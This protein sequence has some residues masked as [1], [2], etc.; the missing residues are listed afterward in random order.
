[1]PEKTPG[2]NSTPL[3]RRRFLRE[4][5][6]GSVPLLLDWAAGRARDLARLM[7]EP[8]RKPALPPAAASAAPPAVQQSLDQRQEEFA[9]DNPDQSVYPSS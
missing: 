2:D 5:L 1:M 6:R 9:R 4:S 8:A 7:Q 3:E